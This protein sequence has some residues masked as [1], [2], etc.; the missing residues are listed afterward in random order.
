MAVDSEGSEGRRARPCALQCAHIAHDIFAYLRL[1]ELRHRVPPHFLASQHDINATMRGILVDWLVEVGEEYKLQRETLHLC[2]NYIDRFLTHVP[3]ARSKLQLVGV[4]CMLLAAKYEDV[5]PPTVDDL[6]Y[7]SDNTYTRDEILAME[8]AVLQRLNFDL[9]A[10]TSIAFLPRF[11]TPLLAADATALCFYLCEL[12]LPEVGFVQFIPS[13]V[14]AAS[15]HL[16]LHTLR[17]PSWS[18]DLE[19]PPPPPL[20]RP[21]APSEPRLLDAAVTGYSRARLA[22]C[23]SALYDLHRTAD[24]AAL[25]AVREKYSSRRFFGVSTLQPAPSSPVAA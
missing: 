13:E 8:G 24:V 15:I 12:T 17:L 16:A 19:A 25:Q 20:P 21:P 23:A 10:V 11:C 14:A 3:V 2:V 1:R 18:A 5:S 4:G 9:S 7:I 6:V 22:G